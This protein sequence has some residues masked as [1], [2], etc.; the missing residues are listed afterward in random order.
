MP[1]PSDSTIFPQTPTPAHNQ[2]PS[3]I[4][5]QPA[6]NNDRFQIE[7]EIGR[8]GFATV[9]RAF[10]KKLGRNVALKVPHQPICDNSHALQLLRREAAA[11]AKLQHPNLVTLYDFHIDT[12][13][14]FLVSELIEGQSLDLWIAAQ[15]T[16]PH[17]Q[18]AA[19]IVLCV[20]Q[21]LAT[22]HQHGILHRDIKPSNILL[23]QNRQ[24]PNLD[25]SPR[26][27]DFGL[28][29]IEAQHSFTFA[30]NTLIGTAY[31]LP[32]ES[33]KGGEQPR[34]AT[35]D[36]Y[37]LCCVLYELLTLKRAFHGG[38][39]EQVY[40]QILKHDFKFP[41]SIVSNIPRDLEAI[42]LQGMALNPLSRYPSAKELA[43]D[44]NR[45]LDHQPVT[46]RRPNAFEAAVRFTRRN[47]IL[48]LA[49][50]SL[51]LLSSSII[52]LQSY[53]NRQLETVNNE[54]NTKTMELEQ[55]LTNSRAQQFTNEQ[56]IY[57]EDMIN[58]ARD[59]QIGDLLR[60]R[61]LL[62]RYKP[63]ARLAHHRD[64]E[65]HQLLQSIQPSHKI[66]WTNPTALYCIATTKDGSKIAVAGA[67]A[68]ITI[69][70]PITGKIDHQIRTNQAEINDLEIDETKDLIFSSGDNGTIACHQFSTG[71]HL[72]TTTLFQDS[73]AYNLAYIPDTQVILCN[74]K[75][76]QLGAIDL[77]SKKVIDSWP[78]PSNNVIC[79]A[80]IPNTTRYLVGTENNI[81]ELWDSKT[82]TQL[83]SFKFES[84]SH[85]H[86][87]NIIVTPNSQKLVAFDLSKNL[88]IFDLQLPKPHQLLNPRSITLEDGIGTASFDPA[89]GDLISTSQF[90]VYSRVSDNGK[91]PLVITER[92][93]DEGQ[94]VHD[95]HFA[96][97]GGTLVDVSQN[98]Q[99]RTWSTKPQPQKPR[100]ALPLDV[101]FVEFLTLTHSSVV[102]HFAVAHQQGIDV[103]NIETSEATRI[104]IGQYAKSALHQPA[105]GTL[106]YSDSDGNLF[107]ADLQQIL[108]R[109]QQVQPSSQLIGGPKILPSVPSAFNVATSEDPSIILGYDNHHKHVCLTT[110]DKQ[111]DNEW[112][113]TWPSEEAHAVAISQKH[114]SIFWNDGI[115]I[116]LASLVNDTPPKTIHTAKV[117]P[118]LMRIS[119]DHKYLVATTRHREAL[120]IDIPNQTLAATLTHPEQIHT[121]AFTPTG[122]TLITVDTSGLL[123]CWNIASG[124]ET[125]T[126]QLDSLPG[127]ELFY[128]LAEDC[129][130]ISIHFPNKELRIYQL[131]R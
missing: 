117:D 41:R 74:G 95:L 131:S 25:F 92:W 34:S 2:P 122:R 80:H 16:P 3:S 81:L 76:W 79:L 112:K 39:I 71:Q 110:I 42:C 108:G 118:T 55:A 91:S 28:A 75:N 26:L 69:L 48:T 116:V 120:L 129:S 88:K 125:F 97:T 105:P 18:T 21:A 44:L 30:T 10:D 35:S 5:Q 124:K 20:A 130:H 65:W 66:L 56:I 121:A 99:V 102:T 107:K 82:Q 6:N 24:E 36:V 128:N 104:A 51:L 83:D 37:C 17:P 45:Y 38:T 46:A 123:R 109:Q 100:V 126:Q 64:F 77:E 19:R 22:A 115:R 58:V 87:V 78:Q 31:Y 59:I 111:A 94:R 114:Q 1:A 60:A 27:T 13:S 4:P 68:I 101:H 54:L 49:T 90:G 127:T 72:W 11:T 23:D 47:P 33:L 29:R 62:D 119:P 52:A 85:S 73:L 113:R 43:D 96:G 63:G 57:A 53:S 98:G 84:S 67:D 7:S 86:I 14:G 61:N 8:G 15:A 70:D 32:P 50:A 103:I 9:Y 106:F 12:N 93:I 89:S 40:S